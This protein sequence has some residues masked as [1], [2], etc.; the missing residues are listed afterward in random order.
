[1]SENQD[2]VL[3]V[4]IESGLER[5]VE[6]LQKYLEVRDSE[7]E[8]GEC[9]G[10]RLDSLKAVS[11]FLI[12]HEDLPYS[13]IKADFDGYADLEWFLPS[14]LQEGEEDD[15]FWGEGDGQVVLRFVTSNLVEFAMLSG[16]WTED[17]ERLSLSGTMSHSKMRAILSLFLARMVS[18]DEG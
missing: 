14:W 17:A 1:M 8:D 12:S 6:E 16:P 15:M 18:Y 2:E 11:R 13:A 10:I 4:L 5:E 7:T 3:E 9:P